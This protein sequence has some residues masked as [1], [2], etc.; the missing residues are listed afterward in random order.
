MLNQICETNM[1]S[2]SINASILEFNWSPIQIFKLLVK[3]TFCSIQY[4]IK[5]TV[6]VRLRGNFV[7]ELDY[8]GNFERKTNIMTK[9]KR[10]SLKITIEIL[11]MH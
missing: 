1:I 5:L 8:E 6:N 2:I 7:C 4:D 10:F 11:T 9:A 3:R